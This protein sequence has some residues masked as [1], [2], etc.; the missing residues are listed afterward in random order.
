M[1]ASL[2]MKRVRN[3]KTNLFLLENIIE[4]EIKIGFLLRAQECMCGA[5]LNHTGLSFHAIMLEVNY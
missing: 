3:D 4:L 1:K 5:L 2:G